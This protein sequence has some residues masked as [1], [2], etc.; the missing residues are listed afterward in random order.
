MKV[1]FFNHLHNGDL[2]VSRE[3][4]RKIINKVLTIHP[5][6]IFIYSHSKDPC[7]LSDIPNLLFDADEIKNINQEDNLIKIGDTIYINTWY[8]QQNGKY[9]IQYGTTM[10]TLYSAFDDTCKEL[11]GFSLNEIS[12]NISDFFP[13]IDYSKFYIET[14]KLWL[15]KHPEKKIFVANGLA[16]SGQATNFNMTKIIIKLAEKYKNITFIL[17]N[18]ESTD[19]LPEN[20]FYSSGIIN[21]K[22]FSDLNENSF[23]SSYCDVII[24]RSSGASTFAITQECLFNKPTKI[25][26]FSIMPK[27]PPNKFWVDS[28][29]KDKVNYSADILGTEE[30][31]VDIVYD[32]IESKLMI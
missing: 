22:Q 2:H 27:I 25:L 11:W 8:A 3:F 10:D 7:L 16:L 28:L 26:Y 21:K 32:I 20:V 4:V 17:T 5:D 29:L 19:T 31:N 6:T 24:G 12:T 15:S 30:D 9:I 13:T 23:I 14:S 1:V 18:I